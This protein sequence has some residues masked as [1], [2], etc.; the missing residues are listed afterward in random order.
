MSAVASRPRGGVADL[1]RLADSGALD[2]LWWALTGVLLSAAQ[3][4][5][6]ESTTPAEAAWIV[7]RR[8]NPTL[9]PSAGHRRPLGVGDQ[10][11]TQD[12]GTPCLPKPGAVAVEDSHRDRLTSAAD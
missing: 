10:L 1:D 2:E 7:A 9:D 11:Q 3:R 4:L 8:A 12:D 6:P 5:A